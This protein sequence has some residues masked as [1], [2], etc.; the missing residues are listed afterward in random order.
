[1]CRRVAERRH[2]Q[3]AEPASSPPAPHSTGRDAPRLPADR[4]PGCPESPTAGPPRCCLRL[5]SML[6][7]PR[8][9]VL[10]SSRPGFAVRPGRTRVCLWFW[11]RRSGAPP[12]LGFQILDLSLL[13]HPCSAS[14]PAVRRGLLPSE[15]SSPSPG[16][17]PVLTFTHT[18][19]HTHARP[20]PG[21]P[22]LPTRGAGAPRGEALCVLS[23][24]R[25]AG[26]GRG[27][28]LPGCLRNE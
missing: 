6:L 26:T 24:A 25:A 4:L 2:S 28:G 14:A 5:G 27:L 3:E 10:A 13:V 12:S 20:R 19:T 23:T 16:W 18:L 17:A 15:F 21:T 11:R 1:M 7:E 9:P 22:S 8:G